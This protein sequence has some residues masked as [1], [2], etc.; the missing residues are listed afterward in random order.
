MS[1]ITTA[2][3]SGPLSNGPD[4]CIQ[5][6]LDFWGADETP[7]KYNECANSTRGQQK[8]DFQTLCCDGNIIDTSDNLFSM[9]PRNMSQYPLDIEN[10]VCCRKAGQ[11]LPGGIMPI[12]TDYTRCEYGLKPTPLASLAATN[13]EN[14]A[15]YLATYE[16]ASGDATG[17]WADWTRTETPTCLWVQ[18]A[19]PDIPMVDVTVPAAAITT[20]PPPT[21]DRWGYTITRSVEGD[22]TRTTASASRSTQNPSRSGPVAASAPSSSAERSKRK[23]LAMLLTSL[24]LG[25]VFSLLL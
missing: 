15:L 13:T 25:L 24:G 4:W 8:S 6:M 1:S 22:G 21:T 19:H 3:P 20:L 5:D 9:A 16:S 23:P 14:A 11:L 18:T 17:G 10:L 7:Y 12:E 2:I